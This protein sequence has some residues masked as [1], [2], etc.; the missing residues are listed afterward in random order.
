VLAALSKAQSF[1]F[2]PA[3]QVDPAAELIAPAL[4]RPFDARDKTVYSAIANALSLGG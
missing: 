2:M 1:T 3:F 4:S